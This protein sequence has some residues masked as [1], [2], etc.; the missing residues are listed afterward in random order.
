LRLPSSS[1]GSP[2]QVARETFSDDPD[3]HISQDPDGTIR[4]IETGTSTE[5]LDVK[6]SHVSC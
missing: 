3:M 5:L 1:D 2:L 6:I 4:I